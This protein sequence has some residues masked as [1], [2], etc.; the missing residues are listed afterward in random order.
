MVRVYLPQALSGMAVVLQDELFG[1]AG[2]DYLS[3]FL[4]AFRSEVDDIIGSHDDG[5]VMFDNDDGVASVNEGVDS[6]E[7]HFDVVKMQTCCRLVEDEECCFLLFL[8]E[9][10]CEFDSL[11]L[12][13]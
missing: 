5:G 7:Q 1:C 9:E 13:S 3:A 10:V 4:S 6:F 8:S 11:A 2:K 12:T